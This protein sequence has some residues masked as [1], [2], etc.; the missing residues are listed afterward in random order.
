VDEARGIRRKPA[1]L[2]AFN[3]R[4]EYPYTLSGSIPST[5]ASQ[6]VPESRLPLP[7]CDFP[8]GGNAFPGPEWRIP[9]QEYDFPLPEWGF[10]SGEY[11]IPVG[12]KYFPLPECRNL[13]PEWR[14]PVGKTRIPDGIKPAPV[15]KWR[16]QRAE[17]PSHPT[18]A[19]DGF[20]MTAIYFTHPE[21]PMKRKAITQ[22]KDLTDPGLLD[23]GRR[24][25]THM[26][27]NE[28]FASPFVSMEDLNDA[29]RAFERAQQKA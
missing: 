29:I 26:L 28:H 16:D 13:L 19:P 1:A 2:T 15:R 27:G 6:T 10:S 3:P 7:K 21:V 5:A 14:N 22:N 23:R 12:E 24:I 18:P 25:H 9:P 17:Y 8:L 20:S 4:P 11:G